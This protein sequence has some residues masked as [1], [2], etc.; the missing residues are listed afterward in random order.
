MTLYVG[1]AVTIKATATDPAKKQPITDATAV[2]DFYAPGKNPKLVVE[3]RVTDK[4]QVT[5]AYDADA[6][7]YLGYVDTTGWEPGKWSVK[8]TLSGS[9]DSWEYGSFTLKP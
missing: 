7:A 9:Y 4:D 6:A 5:M 2:V 8:V 3:D 1:E